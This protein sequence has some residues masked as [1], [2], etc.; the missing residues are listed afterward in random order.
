MHT[1]SIL[2]SISSG[3]HI[4]FLVALY[5][6]VCL[7][8]SLTTVCKRP[9]PFTAIPDK[10]S[11]PGI[12]INIIIIN[13]VYLMYT[14]PFYLKMIPNGSEEE[15]PLA[16]YSEDPSK[17]DCSGPYLCH[18]LYFMGIILSL[19]RKRQETGYYNN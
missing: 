5:K 16:H 15:V 1:I 6:A 17:M 4:L 9:L 13:I 18:R 7:G 2:V 10:G 19:C 14:L 11:K 8:G 12:I 3:F